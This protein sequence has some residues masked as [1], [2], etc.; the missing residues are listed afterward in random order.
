MEHAFGSALN[1]R[2]EGEYDVITLGFLACV[3]ADGVADRLEM[4]LAYERRAHRVLDTG[5]AIA[6]RGIADDMSCQGTLRIDALVSAVGL[7]DRLGE[8]DVVG[9]DDGTTLLLGNALQRMVVA[10]A[11]LQVVRLHDLHVGEVGDESGEKQGEDGD[12][13]GE[14]FAQGGAA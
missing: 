9:G 12:E 5:A 13:P 7:R 1:L 4:L 8:Y 11:V 6:L 2:I 3:G 14:A 10:A